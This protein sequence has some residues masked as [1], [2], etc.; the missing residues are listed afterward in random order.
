MLMS[1]GSVPSSG[2]PALDVTL[3]TSGN[4]RIASRMRPFS[5]CASDTETLVGRKTF[6]QIAPSLS[7]GRNSVPSRGTRARLAAKAT[8]AETIT[9]RGLRSAQ[10]S[11]GA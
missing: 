5:S 2:R 7:S 3:C 1:L 11:A 6:T 9:V 8:T 4:L 10:A